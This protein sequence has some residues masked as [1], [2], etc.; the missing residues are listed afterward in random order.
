MERI[1][2]M[3]KERLVL[4]YYLFYAI[5]AIFSIVYFNGTAHEADSITHYL[6]AKFAFEKPELFLNHW[7][8]PVFVLLAA[9]FAQLG[10]I[11]M[12]IFNAIF[13]FFNFMLIYR[14]ARRLKYR[15]P[16]LAIS[17]LIFCP[18]YFVVIFSGLTE[19]LF[20]TFILLGIYLVLKNKLAYAGLIISFLPFVRS[21][22]LIFLG[23]FAV[24][25]ILS[26]KWKFVF[27]LSIGHIVYAI[28]G[29]FAFNDALWV[30]TDIPYANLNS[31]YGHGNLLHFVVQLQYVI[32][33]PLYILFW[34]GIIENIRKIIKKAFRRRHRY[35]DI[36][37]IFFG[38][39][40]FF[41]AHII[42]WYFGI[43][44]SM[45]LKRVLVGIAPLIILI[46]L[47]GFNYITENLLCN[48]GK[49]RRIVRY[50]LIMYIFIFPFTS[51]PAAIDWEEDMWLSVSQSTVKKIAKYVN[52]RYDE[53]PRLVYNDYF[54]SEALDVEHFNPKRRIDLSKYYLHELKP[55]DLII[56]D[57]WHSVVD[58]GTE[59]ELL[60][61][62]P[63]FKLIKEFTDWDGDR[64]VQYALY[65][66]QRNR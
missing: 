19:I 13:A 26:N 46:C 65:E 34:V 36:I 1:N 12:K 40:C 66:V 38:F 14:I 5:A 37:L 27:Y 21:E 23:L 58:R 24:Y 64:K 48:K 45:G 62:N 6:Y 57:N 25:F 18:L 15:N 10:F 60:D 59:R 54:I 3:P 63:R 16:H 33:I 47:Q 9:P 50:G 7:A 31:P 51:N 43:F 28:A 49:L 4:F 32:G 20:A 53:I 2:R 44:N 61:T 41:L 55:G 8:K 56:W 52:T 11:G 29:V 17:F 42:F 39:L 35:V 30:F 22:G